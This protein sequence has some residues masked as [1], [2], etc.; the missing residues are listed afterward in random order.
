VVKQ[1]VADELQRRQRVWHL[2]FR[3]AGATFANEFDISAGN[4]CCAI[5]SFNNH[6]HHHNFN[7]DTDNFGVYHCVFDN[8]RNRN[9]NTTTNNTNNSNISNNI[10]SNNNPNNI[11]NFFGGDAF[12]DA[13]WCVDDITIDVDIDPFADHGSCWGFSRLS[14]S[15]SFPPGAIAGIAVGVLCCVCILLAILIALRRKQTHDDDAHGEENGAMEVRKLESTYASTGAVLPD[16]GITYTR[17]TSA[18]TKP[19]VYDA[20]LPAPHNYGV[21]PESVTYDEALP[22]ANTHTYGSGST[23]STLSSPYTS[24]PEAADQHHPL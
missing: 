10:I 19:V 15:D 18:L 7:N 17:A 4:A 9:N 3:V 23:S 6:D 22:M 11:T 2:L 24:M 13:Q 14:R 12:C 8:D 5:A 20:V 1:G 16:S 21:V